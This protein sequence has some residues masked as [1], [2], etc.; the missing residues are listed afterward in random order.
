MKDFVESLKWKSEHAKRQA[1]L[2]VGNARTRAIEARKQRSWRQNISNLAQLYPEDAN[3]FLA[4]LESDTASQD[5]VA[6]AERKVKFVD[7]FAAPAGIRPKKPCADCPD[8]I[9]DQV[10][11]VTAGLQATKI[12]AHPYEPKTEAGRTAATDSPGQDDTPFSL[13]EEL[14]EE[15]KLKK[16][17]DLNDFDSVDDLKK[18]LAFEDR[19]KREIRDEVKA[20]L[21]S[22]E[23]EYSGRSSTE[24][25][26]N[27][28]YRKLTEA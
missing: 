4:I 24:K 7:A 14:Y 26:I 13:P 27:A 23:V 3:S 21:D 6:Q 11:R 15:P 18:F 19:P 10:E 16:V 1:L 25:L 17:L 9:A 5:S 12:D 22:N 28:M 20:W 2:A 8:D